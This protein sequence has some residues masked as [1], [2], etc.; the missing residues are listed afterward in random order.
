MRKQVPIA[1]CGEH[2]TSVTFALF[3]AEE[4]Q[5]STIWDGLLGIRPEIPHVYIVWSQHD[6]CGVYR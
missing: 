3:R 4:R 2:E 6:R 5:Q 1:V